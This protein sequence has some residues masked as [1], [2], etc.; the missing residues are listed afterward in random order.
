MSPSALCIKVANV[1]TLCPPHAFHTSLYMH[2]Q[3]SQKYVPRLLTNPHVLVQRSLRCAHTH[4]RHTLRIHTPSITCYLG[5]ITVQERKGRE[6]R[7]EREERG[8]EGGRRGERKSGEMCVLDC[9]SQ[10]YHFLSYSIFPPV[11]NSYLSSLLPSVVT[12]LQ[13]ILPKLK[14]T[15][16]SSRSLDF[17]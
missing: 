13:K 17:K 16:F 14:E 10:H 12:A 4:V 8:R 6:G 3:Q 15:T 11:T 7:R 2:D 1:G 9:K 5:N